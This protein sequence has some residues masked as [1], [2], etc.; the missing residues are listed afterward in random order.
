VVFDRVRA[1]LGA[2]A[3]PDWDSRG[4]RSITSASRS[5][6]KGQLQRRLVGWVSDRPRQTLLACANNRKLC[7]LL[8]AQKLSSRNET[9]ACDSSPRRIVSEWLLRL[10]GG[11]FGYRR[12]DR[13]AGGTA[14]TIRSGESPTGS[15]PSALVVNLL[16]A[17]LQ[18]AAERAG[19]RRDHG[20]R[21]DLHEH[22]EDSSAE[23]DRI[24]DL[25]GDG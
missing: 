20:D 9:A 15:L 6:A 24:L 19:E 11:G 4:R 12:R 18:E 8:A 10:T 21:V 5:D 17:L 16:A 23:R 1:T 7:Q 22:V 13:T 25:R 2:A 14:A 3:S